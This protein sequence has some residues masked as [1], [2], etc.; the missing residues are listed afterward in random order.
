MFFV[1]SPFFSIS[2]TGFW[3][4][5]QWSV[6]CLKHVQN[7]NRQMKIMRLTLRRQSYSTSQDLLLQSARKPPTAELRMVTDARMFMRPLLRIAHACSVYWWLGFRRPQWLCEHQYGKT[8]LIFS[9][10]L[11]SWKLR[12]DSCR[13]SLLGLLYDLCVILANKTK[14]MDASHFPP[15]IYVS[16]ILPPIL[17]QHHKRPTSSN[18]RKRWAHLSFLRTTTT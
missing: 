15:L 4:P 7:F 1:G 14:N 6:L 3:I 11:L 13:F 12:A 9:Y 5:H 17:L 16:K 18:L 8:L 2:N 10:L